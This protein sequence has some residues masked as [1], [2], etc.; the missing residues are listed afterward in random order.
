MDLNSFSVETLLLAAIKSEKE[1]CEVYSVI[2]RRVK[3]AMLKDRLLFLSKEEKKHR[4]IL[5]KI[6]AQKFPSQSIVLPEKSPVPLPEIIISDERMPLSDVFQMAMKA[7][8]AAYDFYLGLSE[9]FEEDELK[10]VFLYLSNMELSHFSILEMEKNTLET[11]EDTDTY[12]PLI[13]E[14]P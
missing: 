2:A 4:S 7:E 3:N 10:N 14:G 8:R 6:F 9:R 13:H 12:V 1:A 5:E 11:F